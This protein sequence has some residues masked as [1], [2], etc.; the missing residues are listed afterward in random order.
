MNYDLEKE[1]DTIRKQREIRQYFLTAY[2]LLLI[3]FIMLAYTVYVN[4]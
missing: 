3:A 2:G 1:F 4:Q